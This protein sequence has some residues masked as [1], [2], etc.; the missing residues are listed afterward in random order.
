GQGVG[1]ALIRAGL[2]ECDG[3]RLPA[4]LE[5]SN[6][7]NTPLYRSHGFELMDTLSI[8][9]GAP[10]LYRMWREARR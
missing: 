10:P 2:S 6:E 8:G 4:Y 3:A 1:G 9:D 7:L 5:N